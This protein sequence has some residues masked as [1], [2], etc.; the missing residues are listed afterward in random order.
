M[1]MQRLSLLRTGNLVLVD[2]MNSIKWQSFNFPTDIMVWGQGLSSK[3]RLTAFPSNSTL[4]YSMEIKDDKIQLFLNYGKSKY[5]YWEYTPSGKRNITFVQLT[6]YGLEIFNGNHKFDQIKST[7]TTTYSRPLRFL[8]LDKTTGN[9]RMYHYSEGSGKFEASY[10]ALNFT[11]DLPMACR[12]YGICMPS[13]SCSCIR[14][15]ADEHVQPGCNEVKDLEGL[16]GKGETEMVELQGVVS[17]LRGDSYMD[18]VGKRACSGFC[19]EDCGCVAAQ[20][21]EGGDGG[22]LGQCFVYRVARGIKTV[23]RGNRVV[24]MVKVGGNDG[25][26]YG[27]GKNSG[28]KKWVIIVVGVVDGFVIFLVLGGLGYYIFWKRRKNLVVRGQGS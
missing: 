28:L 18:G 20:Y 7:N 5:S 6:S 3:T 21:V 9:L 1:S 14:L 24:Y 13:G 25:V 10:R 4:F 22:S 16:C 15:V 12:P 19:N 8:S 27:G 26:N 23:E 11:C 17:V 2:E